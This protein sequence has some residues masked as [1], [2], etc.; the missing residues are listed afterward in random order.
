MRWSLCRV[1]ALPL[2]LLAG[3]GGLLLRPDAAQQTDLPAGVALRSGQIASA[4]GCTL[5]YRLYGPATQ[6]P[7]A[8]GSGAPARG[9]DWVILAHGFLRS[10]A[11]MQGL[12]GAMAADGMQVATLDFCNQKPWAGRHVQNGRDM[13]ALARHLGA[14]RVVYAGFSAGGLA[15]LLAGRAD[16][17]TVGI[18]TLD[19]VETGGLGV[20]AA[21]QLDKPLLALAGEPTNCNA[22]DNGRA[23]LRAT[24]RARV[25]RIAGAGHCD[26]EAPT[27][28]LCELVCADPDGAERTHRA[29]V[30]AG[31]TAA[32]VALFAGD[33]DGW[34]AGAAPDAG[35][36]PD[37]QAGGA[38]LRQP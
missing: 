21:R 26:F 23:V 6:L 33:A 35:P 34:A 32:A 11:R 25:Q 9:G 22:L 16:P 36:G 27:D 17:R 28:G 8:A 3:C 10:Q 1:A 20:G 31:A 15:A 5:D 19:L 12:A 2:L 30:I 18:V 14:E 24:D 37:T 38:H 7:A 29:Q 4:T 13:V